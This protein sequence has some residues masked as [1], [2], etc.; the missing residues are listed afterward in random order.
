MIPLV[1]YGTGGHA[2]EV[3]TLVQSA[4]AVATQF[5]LLGFVDDD[6]VK[7]GSTVKGL[8]VVGIEEAV[9]WDSSL[10]VV[11]AIG[12][13]PT[14]YRV[15]QRLA[16]LGVGSP[17]LVHPHALV[18]TEVILGPGVQIAAGVAITTDVRIGHHVIVNQGC[19]I[20]HDAILHDFVTL[21][22][23]VR[24]SGNVHVGEGSDIGT[25][26]AI[27]QGVRIGEWSVVGAGAAVV[28]DLPPN[29]TAVG[30]PAR[31]IK[32][33]PAGWHQAPSGNLLR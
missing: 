33:R 12:H 16:E 17:A 1:I 3:L 6:P 11:V 23:G 24:V 13:T 4:N 9:S 20:A 18:G 25:G 10:E 7:H 14:R 32:T 8:S 30:V 15:A 21:A 2:R 29:V 22:P 19:T 31:V 27:I 5:E 28:R 26:T